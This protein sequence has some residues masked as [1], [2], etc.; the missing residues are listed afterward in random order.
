MRTAVFRPNESIT[1]CNGIW[2]MP[3][4]KISCAALAAALAL[5]AAG[6]LLVTGASRA[7]N[8]SEAGSARPALT[9]TQAQPQRSTIAL[10]L[11]GQGGVGARQG[12]RTCAQRHRPRLSTIALRLAANGDVAAWQEAS[13]GA[14]SHGLRL[15][16]VLV[17][18]GDRVQA[19]Q[20]LAHFA[21]DTVQADVA[22]AR[23]SLLEAQ[24]HAAEDQ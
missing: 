6:A 10:R 23:A 24:A 8:E 21:T 16:E 15:T 7:A 4:F 22:Q 19:G 5:A 13:I 9:G 3:S 11:G 14:E 12:G 17:N 18:V 2:Q 1:R 20:V